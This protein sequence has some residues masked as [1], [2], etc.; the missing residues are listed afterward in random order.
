MKL[1][2]DASVYNNTHQ[3]MKYIR[4]GFAKCFIIE[5]V[6]PLVGNIVRVWSHNCLL[7]PAYIPTSRNV[8][9]ADRK[10]PQR[11]V[12]KCHYSKA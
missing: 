9:L 4:N 10:S 6:N 1:Q 11:S 12:S 8:N 3:D 5:F 2:Y 7:R